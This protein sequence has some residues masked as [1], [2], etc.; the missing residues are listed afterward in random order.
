MAAF[1]PGPLLSG[2]YACKSYVYSLT[3]AAAHELKRDGSNVKISLLCP[4]PVNTNFNSRAGV[5]FSIKPISA[6]RCA[7]AGLNGM[8]KGKSVIIPGLF[9]KFTVLAMKLLPQDVVMDGCY[10]V[11]NR[12]KKV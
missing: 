1:A 12:K 4:G 11:Q 3:R 8:F 7:A 9:N 10:W 6:K 5:N 2:Y